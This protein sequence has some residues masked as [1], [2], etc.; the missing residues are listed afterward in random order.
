[1]DTVSGEII[2]KQYCHIGVATDTGDGLIVPVVHD[3]DCKSITRIAGELGGLVERTRNR[4]IRLEELQGGSFTVTNIG[5]KGGR[6][7]VAPIINYPEVAILGIG[8][9]RLQPVIRQIEGTPKT[10]PRLIMPVTL[11]I[12]HR[13]LDGV[14]AAH[15]LEF[16]RNTLEDP[17]K[18]LLTIECPTT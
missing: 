3:A 2:R 12:D 16:F 5:A 8:A 6:G 17:E 10:V 1:L 11:T 4:R 7:H 9:A 15:F 14:D 13:V 18:M